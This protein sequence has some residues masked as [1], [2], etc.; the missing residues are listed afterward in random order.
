MSITVERMSGF[1]LTRIIPS[2][3]ELRIRVFREFPYLYEGSSAYEQKYLQTYVKSS[4]AAVIAALDSGKVVGAATALPLE[5][6]TEEVK[7]PFALAGY[8]LDEIFYFGESVLLPEYRGQGV[9]NKF[10]DLR[11]KAAAEAGITTCAFCAVERPMDHPLRP[12]G[13]TP[14]HQFW[15]KRGYHRQ[16]NLVTEFQWQDMGETSESKKRMVFWLRKLKE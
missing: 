16:E 7:R 11:E 5:D 8:Q 6:E 2:L 10:F 1:E 14:L 3:A 9:G 15:Q 4:R 12:A 13:Y